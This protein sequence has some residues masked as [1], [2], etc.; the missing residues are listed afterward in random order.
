MARV[1]TYAI[2]VGDYE[3]SYVNA[4]LQSGAN[5]TPK[6]RWAHLDRLMED[7]LLY[8]EA[9]RLGVDQGSL[10]GE[11]EQLALGKALGGHYFEQAFLRSLPALEEAEIR[12]AFARFKQP[13][14]VRH[15]VYR[16]KA[17]ADGAFSRLRSG[18]SFLE[19][20]QDCFETAEF[21]SLAGYLGAVR[22]FQVDDAFAEAAFALSVGA[23]S[24]P[25]RG[26]HGFHII[27]VEDRLAAPIVTE[28][29]YQMRRSGIASLLRLRQRRLKGDRYVRAFMDSLHVQVDPDGIRSLQAALNRLETRVGQSAVDI[30]DSD[31]RTPSALAPETVLATYHQFGQ[32]HTFT[33]EHYA[34]W[35]PSIPFAEATNRAGAS[36]GRAL[37]NEAFARAGREM[38]LANSPQVMAE[39]DAERRIFLA[40]RMRAQSTDS[41]LL[42]ALRQQASIEVD[43]VLF[44]QIMAL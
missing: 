33:A 42:P 43:T 23:Y 2:T 8:E 26:R 31:S 38:G 29:E 4:L 36:V 34:F 9:Q 15:L 10:T 25:V 21:D 5:D 32:Q 3:Q 13:L 6:Y 14:I 19:E 1:N 24:A 11:L 39:V 12:R 17:E 37:R 28:S 44:N 22:Y 30:S 16:T 20:A 18:R 41:T 35:L 7:H 40:E 27:K